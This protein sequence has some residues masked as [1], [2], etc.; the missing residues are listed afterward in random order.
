MTLPDLV[1][2]PRA[3]LVSSGPPSL[4]IFN[5]SLLQAGYLDLHADA[6]QKPH[7]QGLATQFFLVR[8][9]FP[10]LLTAD[11]PSGI[12]ECSYEVDLVEATAA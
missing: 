3:Y 6:Y 9:G 11:M 1:T 7:Y 4:S 5:D 10:R 8:E 12:L 2:R